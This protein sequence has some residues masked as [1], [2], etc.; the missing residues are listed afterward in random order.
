ML[1]KKDK[2]NVM[3]AMLCFGATLAGFPLLEL[4]R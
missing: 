1:L 3:Q 4:P 2:L